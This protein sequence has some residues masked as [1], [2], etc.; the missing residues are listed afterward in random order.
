MKVKDKLSKADSMAMEADYERYAKIDYLIA[1]RTLEITQPW[2]PGPAYKIG[3]K[4]SKISREP[5]DIAIKKDADK[6]LNRLYWLQRRGDS[7][8]KK[9]DDTEKQMFDL[10][11]KSFQHYN[12]IEVGEQ[13]QLS[14]ASVYRRR[15]AMLEILAAEEGVI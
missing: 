14:Q 8:I 11:F 5:E 6:K 7:A 9:F 4:S 15:A 13:L 2:K 3:G 1:L 10:K 12:W